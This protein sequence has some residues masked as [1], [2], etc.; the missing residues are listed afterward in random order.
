MT[1][2]RHVATPHGRVLTAP[3]DRP[4]GSWRYSSRLALALSGGGARAAYQV[5]VLARLAERLPGL[6]FPI[7]TG[8]SA[9]AINTSYLAAHLGPFPAAVATLREEWTRLTAD[10][11][12]RVRFAPLARAALGWI[13]QGVTLGRRRHASLQGLVDTGPLRDFLAHSVNLGGIDFNIAAGRLRAV[14]LSATSYT[15]RRSVTFVHGRPDM[16]LW[17]RAQRIA[18]RARLTIDHVMASA[19]LPIIFPAIQVGEEFYGDGSVS[20]LAPLAPALHLGARAIVAIGSGSPAVPGSGAG[21]PSAA[22]VIGLLF[23]AIFLDT[24]EADAERLERVNRTIATLPPSEPAPDALRPVELLMLRPSRELTGLAAGNETLL[25]PVI[26]FIVRA[27]GGQHAAASDFLGHLLFHP[28]YTSR[29]VD[30]G[31]EDVAA[32]WPE[33]ER[34]FEKLER[35]EQ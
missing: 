24:L 4:P 27:I 17:E 22:E 9:G 13:W 31:Y 21:Y 5:G 32:Q 25:P 12:Y 34:F 2:V 33:I 20:H 18:V 23:R 6:E 29:L 7:L 14:A 28:D 1:P 30:L 3:G 11:I 35:V 10:R 26:R 19:A 15:T 16:P 8:V